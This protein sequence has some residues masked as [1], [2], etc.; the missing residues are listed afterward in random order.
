MLYQR[1]TCSMTKSEAGSRGNSKLNLLTCTRPPAQRRTPRPRAVPLRRGARPPDLSFQR[2]S[3]LGA[4][5]VYLFTAH[6]FTACCWRSWRLAAACSQLVRSQLVGGGARPF[7]HSS[8]FRAHPGANSQLL[9]SQHIPAPVHSSCVHSSSL[10]A[11]AA[12]TPDRLAI[13]R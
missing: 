5:L 2:S 1:A 8:P 4:A 11:A 13:A 9:R 10:V 7:V 6:P 3:V 12:A